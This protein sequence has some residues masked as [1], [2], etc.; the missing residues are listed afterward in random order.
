MLGE[1]FNPEEYYQFSEY[2]LRHRPGNTLRTKYRNDL[3]RLVNGLPS[4][5]GITKVTDEHKDAL[6]YIFKENDF[7]H[8][9]IYLMAI[10]ILSHTEEDCSNE[11]I[12]QT[13]TMFVSKALEELRH[14]TTSD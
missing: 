5:P 1:Y 9:A 7:L 12:D 4:Y 8:K 14:G 3:F 10:D 13:V 6:D 2:F 11:N